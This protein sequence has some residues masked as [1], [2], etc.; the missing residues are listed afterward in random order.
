MGYLISSGPS[1]W[2]VTLG[3]ASPHRGRADFRAGHGDQ[4]GR[5]SSR[6]EQAKRDQDGEAD[7]SY[8]THFHPPSEQDRGRIFFAVRM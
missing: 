5:G 1:A 4:F 7:P 8:A 3:A 2:S 6:P